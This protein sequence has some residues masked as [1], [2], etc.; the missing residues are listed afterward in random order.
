MATTQPVPQWPGKKRFM[1]SQLARSNI[2]DPHGGSDPCASCGAREFSVCNAIADADLA[3]LAAIAVVTEVPAGRS[4]IDE[5]ESADHFF[6][7]TAGRAKLFKLLPDG[8][9][10]ITGC[11][12]LDP[13]CSGSPE[14]SRRS[15]CQRRPSAILPWQTTPC[16]AIDKPSRVR[17]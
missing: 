7:I 16:R 3:R 10:Q 14:K 1:A 9:R 13:L 6:N 15:A 17:F 8:R 11:V 4:F 5:G 2:L 12:V